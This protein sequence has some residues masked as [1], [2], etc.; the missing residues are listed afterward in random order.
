[1]AVYVSELE[2]YTIRLM[3]VGR[4]LRKNSNSGGWIQI[5]LSHAAGAL[6]ASTGIHR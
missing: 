4:S 2:S 1:M 3:C 5:R 6:T